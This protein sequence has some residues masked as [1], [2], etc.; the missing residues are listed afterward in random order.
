MI[1]KINNRGRAFTGERTF[2]SA[3]IIT[4]F[5]Q[6][7]GAGKTTV[8][9]HLAIGLARRGFKVALV[10]ADEQS[11][12]MNW[13][14][15]AP[16]ESPFPVAMMSLAAMGPTL[17]RE[18]KKHIDNFEFIVVDCPPALNSP[19]PKSAM[20]IADLAIIPM[21][22]SPLDVWAAEPAKDLAKEMKAINEALQIRVLP[23]EVQART[24]LYKEAMNYLMEDQ[25]IPV[26]ESRLA[27][28]T[29]YRECA[30]LG[31]T[32]FEGGSSAAEAI[33]EIETLVTEVLVTLK[34]PERVEA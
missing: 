20:L 3:N 26:M 22:A 15:F 1:A 21:K 9:V 34:S 25:E 4:C 23:N 31:R 33:R 24:T 30:A 2:M 14:K 8:S 28:R 12:A 16:E 19:I 18:L 29:A 10:D 5:N 7:G 6:K 27:L 13:S 11:S 32:V 17:H